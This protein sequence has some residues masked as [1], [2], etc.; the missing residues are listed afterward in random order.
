MEIMILI[1]IIL[2]AEIVNGRNGTKDISIISQQRHSHL[3]EA[4][5]NTI[6]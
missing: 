6:K 1:V 2:I 4:I 5:I 3:G